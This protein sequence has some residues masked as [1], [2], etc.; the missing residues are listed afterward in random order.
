MI[1]IDIATHLKDNV[2]S[3]GGRVFA[4]VIAQDTPR[5]V[6]VY[7]VVSERVS[8]GLSG[9][10]DHDRNARSWDI[11]VY[12]EGYLEA[13]NIKNEVTAALKSFSYTAK[14]ITAEDGFDEESEL[15]AQIITFNTGKE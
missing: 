15:F 14:N 9:A 11:T 1:E 4:N 7:T 2:P 3:V 8:G 10:C 12:A 6:L 5:P 13:K